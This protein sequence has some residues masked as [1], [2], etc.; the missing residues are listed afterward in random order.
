MPGSKLFPQKCIIKNVLTNSHFHLKPSSSITSILFYCPIWTNLKDGQSM[1]WMCRKKPGS[2]DQFSPLK[3]LSSDLLS[4]TNGKHVWNINWCC[5]GVNMQSMASQLD[6]WILT[7]FPYFTNHKLPNY[8]STF[9]ILVWTVCTKI[10]NFSI[11]FFKMFNY[12]T[13]HFP[14]WDI[15]CVDSQQLCKN[16]RNS[17][18]VRGWEWSKLNFQLFPKFPNQCGNP[19]LRRMS[20]WFKASNIHHIS[21]ITGTHRTIYK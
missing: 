17:Q 15:F 3:P 16:V 14:K 13:D 1:C 4:Y 18:P 20:P 9:L 10:P 6:I 2:R 21:V 19:A 11:F 8:F 12:A 5:S 7:G